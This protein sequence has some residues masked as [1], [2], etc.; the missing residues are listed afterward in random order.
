MKKKLICFILLFSS[1]ASAADFPSFLK[2][3][4]YG[5]LAGTLAG[6]ASLALT[7]KPSEHGNNIARGASLG[8]YAGIAYGLLKKPTTPAMPV[9]DI[10]GGLSPVMNQGQVVGAQVFMQVYRF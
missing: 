1:A 3:C 7:D 2:S 6:V 9:E 4:A 10:Y 5:T 8:L